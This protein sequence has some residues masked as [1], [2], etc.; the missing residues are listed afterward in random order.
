MLIYFFIIKHYL[1]FIY[2]WSTNIILRRD[3]FFRSFSFFFDL[4]NRNVTVVFNR[5]LAYYLFILIMI[6]LPI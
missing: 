6:V 5:L 3:I 4:N 2:D 1:L